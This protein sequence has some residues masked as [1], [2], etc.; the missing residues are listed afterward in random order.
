MLYYDWA[1]KKLKPIITH[2]MFTKVHIVTYP[3]L[4]FEIT[5]S[6]SW[7][8]DWSIDWFIIRLSSGA[9]TT[10]VLPHQNTQ[11]Q[12]IH[13]HADIHNYNLYLH[14]T[15]QIQNKQ[16]NHT[17]SCIKVYKSITVQKMI[18]NIRRKSWRHSKIVW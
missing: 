11:I 8:I 6:I 2:N 4:W 13:V 1:E 9:R 12:D 3:T 10:A 17:I 7:L 14:T 18:I 5:S 16:T 15:I